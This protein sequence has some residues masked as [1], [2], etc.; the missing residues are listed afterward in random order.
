[1]L[2]LGSS[3]ASLIQPNPAE[4]PFRPL[5]KTS[6]FLDGLDHA[7]EPVNADRRILAA[8]GP[9]MLQLARERTSGVHPSLVTPDYV[10][11]LRSN[12]GPDKLIVVEQP[13]VLDSN[14]D[15]ARAIARAHLRRHLPL[16]VYQASFTRMGFAEE[17]LVDDG[18]D[19][20]IDGLVAWGDEN[21]IL[22]RITAHHHAG[23]DQVC[24]NALSFDR[25]EHPIGQ[26]RALAPVLNS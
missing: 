19:R 11:T 6:E 26:W 18:S 5:A 16:A 10:N 23:A 15:S 21:A 20:L 24:I 17:D 13:V 8:H 9:K 22:K 1:M 25:L 3:H 4:Q 14:P 7:A 12:V 2:G